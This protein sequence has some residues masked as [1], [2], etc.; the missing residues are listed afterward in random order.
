MNPNYTLLLSR[1]F[2]SGVLAMSILSLLLLSG[3]IFG[4]LHSSQPEKE[5]KLVAGKA[6]PEKSD[7]YKARYEEGIKAYSEG[8]NDKALA[9]FDEILEKDKHYYKAL[10][11]KG[12]ILAFRG[13]TEQGLQLVKQAHEL[14]P[15]DGA[16]YYNLAMVYKLKGDLDNAK[17][18]FEK[19]LQKDPQNTWSYYG[20]STIY[21]DKRQ[22]KE[23]LHYL[24]KAIALDPAVKEVAKSQDHFAQLLEDADFKALTK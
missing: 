23:A 24:E 20:I 1:F 9:I 10:S 2:K 15:E 6:T 19:T 5:S 22:K 11:V 8:D 14:A 18:W 7:L 3:C 17:V 13:K 4:E 16:V 21:A 12:L